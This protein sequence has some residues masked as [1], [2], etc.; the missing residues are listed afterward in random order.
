[1]VRFEKDKLVIE[2]D[3]SGPFG[4]LEEWV[5][6]HDAMCDLIYFLDSERI[7]DRTFFNI[8]TLIRALV[9]DWGTVKK[10][11]DEEPEKY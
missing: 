2:I 5:N 4:P 1:M 10:M 9:P 6:L 3:A 8:A 11:C 7:N